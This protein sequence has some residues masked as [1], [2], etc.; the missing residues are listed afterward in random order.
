MLNL[1]KKNATAT[2]QLTEVQN[3]ISD[4]QAAQT[5][6]DE[7]TKA[8]QMEAEMIAVDLAA[9]DA[10]AIARHAEIDVELARI[11]REID[12]GTRVLAELGDAQGQAREAIKAE[13]EAAQQAE[14]V[15]VAKARL[16]ALPGQIDELRRCGE[17]VI[18]IAVALRSMGIPL[19][20][21]HVPNADFYE[22]TAREYLEYHST[23]G[24]EHPVDRH[25]REE[26]EA[27]QRA[28]RA[29]QE[30]AP[31]VSEAELNSRIARASPEELERLR[32]YQTARADEVRHY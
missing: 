17:R 6:R 11:K 8:L 24:A 19:P 18:E 15:K 2:D 27:H 14:A 4:V 10:T 12:V 3:K 31:A 1:F 7:R 30:R 29:N 32:L 26:R 23:P 21:T 9:G 16:K 25:Q 28:I 5:K 20:E 13:Q 22:A